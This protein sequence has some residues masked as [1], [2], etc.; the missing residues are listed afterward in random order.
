MY[1]T[2]SHIFQNISHSIGSTDEEMLD[3]LVPHTEEDDREISGKFDRWDAIATVVMSIVSLISLIGLAAGA[4]WGV[5]ILIPL[6]PAGGIG[7]SSTMQCNLM[8]FVGTQVISAPG[9]IKDVHH[10][11]AS[12]LREQFDT[13]EDFVLTL[14]R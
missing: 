1:T 11:I 4:L 5:K 7:V 12:Y 8:F 2:A 6:I 13:P 9:A 10:R 14:T 3:L